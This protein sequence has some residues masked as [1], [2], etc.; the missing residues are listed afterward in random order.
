MFVKLGLVVLVVAIFFVAFSSEINEYFPNAAT[1]GIDSLKQDL[2][3]LTRQQLSS[4]EL[5]IDSSSQDIHTRLSD[6]GN[7]IV[8][9]TSHTFVQAED[10]LDS[11]AQQISQD[12][13]DTSAEFIEKNVTEKLES[14]S[15]Q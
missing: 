14:I 9:A 10:Q 12:L 8:D 2:D 3:S 13:G 7:K 6:M 15:G 4:V 1:T 5:Q 11:V